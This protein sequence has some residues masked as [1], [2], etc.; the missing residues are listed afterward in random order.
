MIRLY[1]TSGSPYCHRVRIVLAEKELDYQVVPVDLSKQENRTEQFLRLNPIGKVPV[2]T[3]E[4][5][6]LSESLVINEYLNE[7]YPY[8]ELMPE[9]P[10]MKAQV[11]VWSYQIDSMVT[12]QFHQFF[13]AMMAKEKGETFDEGKLEEAK[14][15]IYKFLE[16]ADRTL[17]S[18]EYLVGAY[19][20]ADIA[21]APW[22]SRFEKYG[23]AVPENLANISAWM[24]R[25]VTR[26][27]VV[28][29]K[30]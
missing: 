23:V 12:S 5:L 28:S 11:R 8:P 26:H 29:T 30:A 2:L 4:D 22:V 21:F 9:D 16:L 10:N 24:K 3:D 20:L 7:E 18:K 13:L 19:S 6:I 25:L 15:N 1:Q 17:K 14:K 27:S